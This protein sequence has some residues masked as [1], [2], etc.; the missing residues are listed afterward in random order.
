MAS[1][2]T[3]KHL[4]RTEGKISTTTTKANNIQWRD[5]LAFIASL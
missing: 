3:P 1:S 5:T 2:F 4:S